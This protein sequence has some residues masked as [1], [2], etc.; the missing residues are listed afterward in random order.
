MS[1]RAHTSLAYPQSPCH[2]SFLETSA[3]FDL[4]FQNHLLCLLSGHPT[5]LVSSSLP[6]ISPCPSASWA[7]FLFSPLRYQ[8]PAHSPRPHPP[9]LPPCSVASFSFTVLNST[10]HPCTDK[11]SSPLLSSLNP[12]SWGHRRSLLSVMVSEPVPSQTLQTGVSNSV[13][14]VI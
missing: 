13:C 11:L 4:S 8:Y 14:F 7:S 2:L 10:P 6:A 9:S 1:P 3:A 12:G 5:L